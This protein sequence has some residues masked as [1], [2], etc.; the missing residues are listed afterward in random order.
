MPYSSNIFDDYIG[1]LIDLLRPSTVLDIGVG[2]GK[3]SDLIR[4]KHKTIPGYGPTITGVEI[5]ESYVDRFELDL[6][7]DHLII[8]DAI[9]LIKK[10]Q[11]R[12]GLV[13]IGDC[14]EHMRKSHAIDLINFLIYR[15]GYICIVYPDK[16]IQDDWEGHEAEAHI[17]V[18][19]AEDFK[20]M[21]LIHRTWEDM[22][23]F[24]IKG[25]QPSRMTIQ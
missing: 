18:W 17:S 20:G 13:I 23:L 25:Y 11:E 7:Y 8:G 24:L 5:D 12:Y 6:K 19:S 21:D 4:A 9:D 3:Y 1:Q 14:I 16:Y 2:A 10:P 15:S 22:N